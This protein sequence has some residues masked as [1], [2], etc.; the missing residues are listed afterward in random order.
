MHPGRVEALLELF[1]RRHATLGRCLKP[2]S[3]AER[4]TLSGKTQSS[5]TSVEVGGGDDLRSKAASR[6]AGAVTTHACQRSWCRPSGAPSLERMLLICT[7]TSKATATYDCTQLHHG[8][9]EIEKHG[10]SFPQQLRGDGSH[11]QYFDELWSQWIRSAH[12]LRAQMSSTEGTTAR[13]SIR[14]GREDARDEE[15]GS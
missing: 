6:S 14:G 12:A 8:H 15:R 11:R 9:C 2:R 7:S 13:V 10:T 5:A 3:V 4:R 1:R